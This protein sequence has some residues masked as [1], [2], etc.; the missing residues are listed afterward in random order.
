MGD[1]SEDDIDACVMDYL[2]TIKAK[3]GA[4]KALEYTPVVFR[5]SPNDLHFQQVR[6]K[7]Q[8]FHFICVIN[9]EQLYKYVGV[10][11]YLIIGVLEGY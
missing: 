2:G 8:K 7:M 6:P 3:R 5:P 9:L 4:E 11:L 1:F 10:F